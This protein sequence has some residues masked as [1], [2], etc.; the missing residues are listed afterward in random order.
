MNPYLGHDAVQPFLEDPERGVF[1]LCKTSNPGA[2]DLQDLRLLEQGGQMVYEAVARLAQSWNEKDNLGLVVGATHPAALQNVRAAAPNLWILAPGV[3]AQGGDLQ[4]ALAAGLRADGLGLLIPV[5]RALS[6]S[7]DP[8]QAAQ[9]L[10]DQINRQRASLPAASQ[11]SLQPPVVRG[12]WASLATG[13]LDAGCVKFGQF[14][15]KSGL[16]SPVYLDLRQLVTYPKLLAQVAGA[17]LPILQK[18]S[19]DRLAALPYAALPMGTAVSVLGGW[20]LIYPRKEVKDYGTKAEI[21]GLFQPGERVAVID[22][23]TTTG[24]SKFEAIERLTAAGL[25]VQDIIVLIDRQAEAGEALAQKG[26]RL[27]AVFTLIQ[28]LDYWQGAGRVSAEQAAAVRQFLHDTR[29][30][31]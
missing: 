13:L 15:L 2:G 18:L 23:L 1:L 25:Q 8:R 30:T 4:A 24:G 5:S 26:C 16:Q 6:R 12:P 10:S 31:S 19:F 11:P 9:D 28:L 7:A 17:Y 14:T 20:P 27:H 21:E 3:G 29:R 22:D